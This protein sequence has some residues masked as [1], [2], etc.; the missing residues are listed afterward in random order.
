MRTLNLSTEP[1]AFIGLGVIVRA[2]SMIC[3]VANRT[4]EKL[5]HN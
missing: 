2:L 3:N 4:V 5:L 1:W